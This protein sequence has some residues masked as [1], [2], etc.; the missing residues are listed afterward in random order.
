LRR[1]TLDAL[2][3]DKRSMAS[4]AN[5]SYEELDRYYDEAMRDES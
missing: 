3:T 4:T 5:K 2:K 1:Q